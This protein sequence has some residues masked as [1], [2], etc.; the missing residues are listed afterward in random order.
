MLTD[1]LKTYTETEMEKTNENSH[2]TQ[3]TNKT[4]FCFI[5]N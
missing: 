1:L 4:H 3:I 5:P 2:S